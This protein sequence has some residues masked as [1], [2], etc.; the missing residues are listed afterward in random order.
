VF[1]IL[2]VALEGRSV[3]NMIKVRSD[4][5]E[6]SKVAGDFPKYLVTTVAGVL[7]AKFIVFCLPINVDYEN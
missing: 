7:N 6:E 2:A 4:V 1:H 3:G 5:L